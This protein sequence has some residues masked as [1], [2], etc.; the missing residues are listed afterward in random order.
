MV[1]IVFSGEYGVML[2]DVLN[3][4]P[5]VGSAIDLSVKYFRNNPE[6]TRLHTHALRKRLK[7]KDA[8]SVTKDMRIVFEWVG[9]TTVRFLA[10]GR[11]K[12]VYGSK[13]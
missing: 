10:V 12:D 13:R 1:K 6:D 5:N 3:T 2:A 8:F 4:H 9:K 7:G 11:H